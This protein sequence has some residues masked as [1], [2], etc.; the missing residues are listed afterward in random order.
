V[1]LSDNEV[2]VALAR[3]AFKQDHPGEPSPDNN[4]VMRDWAENGNAERYRRFVEAHPG[5]RVNLGDFNA[6]AN[7]YAAIL[8]ESPKTIH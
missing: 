5:N 7:T 3:L 2:Q 1:P 4:T 8:G 6:L